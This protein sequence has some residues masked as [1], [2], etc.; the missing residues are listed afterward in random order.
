M[1]LVLLAPAASADRVYHSEHL[2]LMPVGDQPLRSGF[3]ENIHA[4]GPVV[5]ALERYVLNGA[6]PNTTY[7]VRLDIWMGGACDGDPA[8]TLPSASF[9]TN[10]AGNAVGMVRFSPEDAAGLRGQLLGIVWR[11]ETGGTTAYATACSD[12]QLD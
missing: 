2:R 7:D 11:L 6:E 8:M 5:F 1:L 3:V 9:T 10:D 12:V 4:S